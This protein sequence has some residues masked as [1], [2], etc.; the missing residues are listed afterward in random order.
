MWIKVKSNTYASGV[1]LAAGAILNAPDDLSE[2]DAKLLI[3]HRRA[4]QV[5]EPSPAK[6]V[7]ED[8]KIDEK[9]TKG[10]IKK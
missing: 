9:K 1:A 3:L 7:E 5:M 4:I 6:P 10:R 2:S 8:V